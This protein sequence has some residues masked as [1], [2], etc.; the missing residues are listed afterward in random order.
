M[1][2]QR[3]LLL[4]IAFLVLM[5]QAFGA[6]PEQPAATPSSA[7]PQASESAKQ[8]IAASFGAV[9]QSATPAPAL[10]RRNARYAIQKNDALTLNFTFTPEYNETTTVQPDGYISLV[11]LPD[12]H[13]EGMTVPELNQ[14]LRDKYSKLLHDPVVTVNVTSF[15]QP[16]FTAMGMVGKP[17][18]Y[19]LHGETTLTEGIALA[20]GFADREAKHSDVLLFRK[21]SDQWVEARKFNMKRMFKHGQLTEDP[22]L[23]PGDL[24][25]IPKNNLSKVEEFTP[26]LLP[27]EFF[28]VSVISTGY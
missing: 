19:E 15:V 5:A 6:G 28:R 8:E 17:G 16:T 22:E 23:Q 13:V 24:I 21:V 25:F 11:G 12:L 10:Q 4:V 18:R 2:K 7:L 3:A 1:T 26:F 20:G 27:L 14:T 9:N